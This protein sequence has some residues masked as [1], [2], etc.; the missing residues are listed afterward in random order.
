M[1]RLVANLMS[2]YVQNALI[3]LK[4]PIRGEHRRI[5]TRAD[6]ANEEVGIGALHAFATTP[7]EELGS[8][9]TVVRVQPK[10][11]ECTKPVAQPF[12][13]LLSPNS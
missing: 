10:V 13:L 3:R 1:D 5:A 8:Q 9:F 7:V 11:R 2:S 12:V 4:I 6:R